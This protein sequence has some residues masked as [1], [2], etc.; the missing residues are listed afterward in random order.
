[1]MN[2]D[3]NAGH[4][5]GVVLVQYLGAGP[6]K[7]ISYCPFAHKIGG[8]SGMPSKM[9]Y[10]LLQQYQQHWLHV[11]ARES[12]ESSTKMDLWLL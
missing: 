8:P 2:V 1:M 7:T 11:I 3:G 4:L 9:L 6:M 10:E 12:L 5:R